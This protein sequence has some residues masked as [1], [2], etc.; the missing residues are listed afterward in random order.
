MMMQAGTFDE[1]LSDGGDSLTG[2]VVLRCEG[3]TAHRDD[4]ELLSGVTFEVRAGE[5]VAI[6]VESEWCARLVPRIAI[7]IEDS[8]EGEIELLGTRLG[9]LDEYGE[10][11]LRSKVGY[12]F[13][14]S[15]LI[16]NLTVWYNVA[17]PALYHSRFADIQGVSGRVEQLIDRC[18]LREFSEV[19]PAKLNEA[20]RKRVALARAWVMAPPL[21]ILE[22][23][24]VDIDSGS[25][26]ELL[27]LALGPTPAEW[28]GRDPRPHKPGILI[29]SQ[30]LHEGLFRYVDNL[31]IIKDGRVVFS[32]CPRDF[33][34]RGKIHPEDILKKKEA[35]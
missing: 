9:S 32:E 27:D 6:V 5:I 28:E 2:E 8:N 22:D 3:L 34:R 16:H 12:L 23:P 7:G 25:G 31:I 26:G 17:L 33:D 21:L 13:H 19:R 15:G 10:L 18:N 30:E 24:L 20:T 14:N 4:E 1:V 35:F 11:A 29:T